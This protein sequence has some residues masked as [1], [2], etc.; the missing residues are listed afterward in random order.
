MTRTFG[1]KIMTLDFAAEWKAKEQA[2]ARKHFK[3]IGADPE[4]VSDILRLLDPEQDKKAISAALSL[5]GS[6]PPEEAFYQIAGQEGQRAK[7]IRLASPP[8]DHLPAA[9]GV[10]GN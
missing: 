4:S 2:K 5:I 6:P 3:K 10:P 1:L 8:S 7:R 9:V